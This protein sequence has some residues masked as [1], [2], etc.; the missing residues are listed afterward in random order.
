MAYKCVAFHQIHDTN[1]VVVSIQ[2][3]EEAHKQVQWLVQAKSS[4]WI[5]LGDF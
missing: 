3:N 5:T 4:K 2:I 1:V